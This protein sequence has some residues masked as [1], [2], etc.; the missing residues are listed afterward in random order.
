MKN[1]LRVLR[2]CKVTWV[3][4]TN[5]IPKVILQTWATAALPPHLVT[6]VQT[7]RDANPGFQYRFFDDTA[8]RTLIVSHFSERVLCAWDLLLPG[9]YRADLFRLCALQVYGGV[10]V[11]IKLT[12]PIRLDEY[13]T[14]GACFVDDGTFTKNG[15]TLHS[16][17]NG[18]MMVERADPRLQ[19]TIDRICDNISRR[20]YETGPLDVTGPQVL[21]AVLQLQ[22]FRLQHRFLNGRSEILDTTTNKA[23]LFVCDGYR[24][25]QAKATYYKN[26]YRERRIYYEPRVYL[27]LPYFGAFPNYFQL[28]LDSVAKNSAVLTVVLVTDIALDAYNL[29][30][31]IEVVRRTRAEL[32]VQFQRADHGLALGPI[33]LPDA[34]KLVDWKPLLPLVFREYAK[35]TNDYLAYGD[36]D[37][38]YGN[39]TKFLDFKH[40]VMGGTYGHFTALRNTDRVLRCPLG[41]PNLGA[42]LSDESKTYIVDEKHFAPYL[43]A[44]K[45]FVQDLRPVLCDVVPPCYYRQ[46]RKVLQPKNFFCVAQPLKNIKMLTVLGPN[47]TVTYDGETTTTDVM[48]VHLQ[49]RDMVLPDNLPAQYLIYE[50][51]FVPLRYRLHLPAIPHTQ[52]TQQYTNSAFV[53][54]IIK[55]APM[56]QAQGYEVIHY[57]VEGSL[58]VGDRNIDILNKKEWNALRVMSLCDLRPGLM[59]ADAE[60]MLADPTELVDV[61]ANYSTKLYDAFNTKLK[62][63]L[64]LTYRHRA[65]DMV[66]LPFGAAHN[67][68][69]KGLDVLTC[70]TGVGYNHSFSAYRIFESYAWLHHETTENVPNYWFVAPISYPVNRLPFNLQNPATPVVGFFARIG[71]GKGCHILVEVARRLPHVKFVLCGQGNPSPFLS[72]PNIEYRPPCVGADRWAYLSSLTCLL[73][74]T[75]Y[76][77]PFGSAQVEAQICGTP[78]VCSN[79]GGPTETVEHGRTGYR[80]HTL[81]DFVHGVQQAI[82]GKYNRAYVR[83]RTKKLYDTPVV[84]SKVHSILQNIFDVARDGWYSS[85]CHEP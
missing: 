52:T 2:F 55:F 35:N 21:G 53:S 14:E 54:K 34:Y 41:V 32:V 62:A 57:A 37:L 80:C 27:V 81:A 11:D 78:V 67:A 16:V 5:M 66:C 22:T 58:Q 68:A 36:C 3:S 82:D 47:L 71:T 19:T 60:R 31:N 1:K 12:G 43:H 70:E 48:Y 4:R 76:C 59:A 28:Y 79:N 45:F 15:T 50:H 84:G 51:K 18:V 10:Y 65:I 75:T 8:C 20:S 6:A 29:P 13:L 61:L 26:M 38:V 69:L 30:T 17:Y 39:L 64:Q 7:L 63:A 46:F 9:A 33:T 56:M 40:N 42:M 44:Q 49:K 77:E 83:L 72:E 85:T 23:V 24:Q 74:P 25:N 73:A